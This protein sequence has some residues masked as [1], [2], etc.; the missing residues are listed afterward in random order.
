MCEQIAG[1]T[2]KLVKTSLVADYL[3]SRSV[4]E[5]SVFSRFFFRSPLSNVEETTLQ[6]GGR[7]LWRIVAELA[8]KQETDLT[9]AY[10]RLGDL[11]AVAG[12]LLPDRPGSGLENPRRREGIPWSGRHAFSCR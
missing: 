2:K 3:R 7:S 6:I 1:T 9:A 10:R 12:Y 4:D 11:G 8:E 5:A